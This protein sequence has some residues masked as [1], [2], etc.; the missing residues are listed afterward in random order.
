[1]F[2]NQKLFGLK[3]NIFTLLFTC[4]LCFVSTSFKSSSPAGTCS[5]NQPIFGV[6][7]VTYYKLPELN[8]QIDSDVKG[9]KK[10]IISIKKKNKEEEKT[11]DEDDEFKDIEVTYVDDKEAELQILKSK[12]DKAK[13]AK[14]AV[15]DMVLFKQEL[16]RILKENDEKDELRKLKKQHKVK[17]AKYQS[18]E[19]KYN[20]I[21]AE[22]EDVK[23]RDHEMHGF[24]VY[25]SIEEKNSSKK[26][27][28]NKKLQDKIEKYSINSSEFDEEEGEFN[29]ILTEDL[30]VRDEYEEL[31]D[32]ELAVDDYSTHDVELIENDADEDVDLSDDV[33]EKYYEDVSKE[34]KYKKQKKPKKEIEEEEDNSELFQD[35]LEE[36]HNNWETIEENEVY[37]TSDMDTFEGLMV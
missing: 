6:A 26:E 5:R 4:L 35:I 25:G 27:R 33:Y 1:M 3:I 11:L 34:K 17:K 19:Q 10:S 20:A 24:K 36:D 31:N 14:D 12:E 22:F 15:E 18:E 30:E 21:M 29:D 2:H 9:K 23:K 8:T 28:K 37:E 13:E 16:D 7:P 32:Q